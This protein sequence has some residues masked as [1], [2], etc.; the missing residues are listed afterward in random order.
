MEHKVNKQAIGWVLLFAALTAAIVVKFVRTAP[1]LYVGL[2]AF[3]CCLFL[4]F[5]FNRSRF[6][7]T[8]FYLLGIAMLLGGATEAYFA[9]F[10]TSLIRKDEIQTREWSL[11]GGDYYVADDVRGYAAGPDVS[12]RI[13]KTL[14]E[15]VIYDVVYTT[16]GQ[17]LRVAPH[18]VKGTHRGSSE[19]VQNVVFMGDSFI[20]G[21]GLNDEETIPYQFEEL[22]GG[23]CTTY[24]FGFHGYGAQQML[25]V[26]ETGL[27]EKIIPG[28][29]PLVVVYG[30]LLQHIERASGKMIWDAKVPRYTLTPSGVAEFV[31]TF[32]DDP[33]LEENL[34]RSRG[35][36]D[37]RAQLLAG[38]AGPAR[39][40][41]DIRLFVQLVLQTR[42]L[43]AKRHQA[44]F[45]VLLWP[46]G[47]KDAS[48][49]MS[50]L[51]KAGIEVIS[52][53]DIL[54]EYPE[55]PEKYRIEMD[56]HP[57]KLATERI[58]TFLYQH[59]R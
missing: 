26:V 36:S 9:W 38:L 41:E 58:A 24:N 13:R 21:E 39:T 55:P 34:K 22:S 59:L 11:R 14:G 49:V 28:R 37:P 25:R 54:K 56:N 40:P 8:F 57:T 7:K 20:F 44:R 23:R 2:L 50:E 48:A 45:S 10:G 3:L 1:F 35:L 4:S 16:N 32:A 15:K 53:D 31:G 18:D 33:H 42:D 12:K 43:L 19:D 52:T 30:A 47:D 6:W 17:G 46:L 27:L 5:S 29:Q 51:R